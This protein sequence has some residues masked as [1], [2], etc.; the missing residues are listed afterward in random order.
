MRVNHL[1][2]CQGHGEDILSSGVVAVAAV[3]CAVSQCMCASSM[4]PQQVALEHSFSLFGVLF[5]LQAAMF[6]WPGNHEDLKQAAFCASTLGF[7]NK[8]TVQ[9]FLTG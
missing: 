6:T 2:W 7:R 3:V 8:T 5:P 9:S 4:A 1:G